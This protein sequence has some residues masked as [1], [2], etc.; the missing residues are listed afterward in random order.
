M[1]ET[2]LTTPAATSA[3][4]PSEGFGLAHCAAGVRNAKA[5]EVRKV[6]AMSARPGM[7]SFASGMPELG[8]LPY[9][10]LAGIAAGLLRERGPEVMQYGAS[11]GTPGLKEQILGLMRLEGIENAAPDDV[12]VTTGSQNGLDLLSRILIDPGDVVLAESP[13]YSGALAVFT[14]AQAEVVHVPS[15]TRGLLPDELERTIEDLQLQGR[16]IKFLYTIPSYQN[17]GGTM[18]PQERRDRVREICAAA[19]VLVAEDNPY[20]LLGFEGAPARAM[21]ADDPNVVYL[22]SVSKMFAPGPRVGWAV[23]PPSLAR[24]FGLQAEAAVLNPSVLTQ[25]IVASYLRDIDWQ[26]V[27]EHYRALYAGRARA[28]VRGLEE[29]MPDDVTWTVPQGGFYCWLTLPEGIDSYELCLA[30]IERGVV[31]VPGTAFYTDGRG[32]REARL[33]YCHPTEERI[34]EG[35]RIL[36][37][38]LTALLA[39]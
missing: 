26:A 32:H 33:S 20:G 3:R 8:A 22:G 15:D 14:G 2:A 17:P 23:L 9:E 19:R 24:P 39:R 37:D 30:A 18:L 28:L 10:Q 1:T 21:R 38:T 27:L 25:E 6:F 5:S 35:A 11:T 12:V 34:A 29:H 31:F 4:T 36:G 13:S 16:R 7:I